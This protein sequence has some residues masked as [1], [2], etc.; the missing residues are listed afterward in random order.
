MSIFIQFNPLH[1]VI[2]QQVSFQI[3]YNSHVWSNVGLLTLMLRTYIKV[4]KTTW[5]PHNYSSSLTSLRCIILRAELEAALDQI[6]IL[7]RI[8][9]RNMSLEYK[10]DTNVTVLYNSDN[11]QWYWLG[12]FI[13]SF[14][15]VLTW[16]W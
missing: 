5:M 3:Y 9:M 1:I 13:W 2:N 16:V 8:C 11:T 12:R 4:V 6:T 10:K 15:N 14:C 7:L